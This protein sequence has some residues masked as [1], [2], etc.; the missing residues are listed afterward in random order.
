MIE[1]IIGNLITVRFPFS[2]QGGC[3]TLSGLVYNRYMVRNFVLLPPE[4]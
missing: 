2:N 1:A 4:H 3:R